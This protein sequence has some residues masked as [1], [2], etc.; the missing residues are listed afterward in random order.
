MYLPHRSNQPEAVS[1]PWTTF[2][3]NDSRTTPL[4]VSELRNLT[5]TDIQSAEKTLPMELRT[6]YFNPKWRQENQAHSYDARGR[7]LSRIPICTE[8]KA[9]PNKIYPDSGFKGNV[10]SAVSL[11]SRA[12]VHSESGRRHRRLK[13]PAAPE[14]SVAFVGRIRRT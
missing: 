14:I 8:S 3:G 1:L 12:C 4:F 11:E 13:I 6:R 5:K 9:E 10:T 7:R 2:P